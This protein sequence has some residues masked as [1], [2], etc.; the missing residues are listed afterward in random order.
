MTLR[1]LFRLDLG[2]KQ[3]RVILYLAEGEATFEEL[4]QAL[5]VSKTQ[6]YEAVSPLVRQGLIEKEG[7]KYRLSLA[8]E[9]LFNPSEEKAEAKRARGKTWW[10]RALR[11]GPRGQ[12]KKRLSAG[13]RARPM[14]PHRPADL[15]SLWAKWRGTGSRG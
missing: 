8:L 15:A 11:E 10:S 3:Y 2:R 13:R 1:D 5:G 6:G 9:G 7:N 12:T 4:C 14:A